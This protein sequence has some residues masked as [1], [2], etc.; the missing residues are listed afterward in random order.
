MDVRCDRR[1][2]KEGDTLGLVDRMVVMG[3]QRPQPT[4]HTQPGQVHDSD[5]ETKAGSGAE[6][7]G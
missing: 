2:F 3:A 4:M 5:Q 7:Q 6:W 1:E